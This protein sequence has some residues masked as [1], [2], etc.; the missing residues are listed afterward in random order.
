MKTFK[1]IIIAS[2]AFML[3]F[4]LSCCSSDTDFITVGEDPFSMDD[5]ELNNND[6]NV[7]EEDDVVLSSSSSKK[8]SSSSSSENCDDESSSKSTTKKDGG[9]DDGKVDS[10][11]DGKDDGKSGSKD[12]DKP[13]CSNSKEEVTSSSKTVV[14]SSSKKEESSS[15]QKGPEAESSSSSKKK[16][17][18]GMEEDEGETKSSASKDKT[19]S[20]SEKPVVSS[21]SEKP[22]VSSSSEA[23]KDTTQ[24]IE[25]SER[26]ES[27]DPI[28][29]SA[30]HEIE[31]LIQ[32]GDSAIVKVDSLV[33]DKQ[34]M[35]FD[36]NEYLCK[37]PDGSWYKLR[38]KKFKG[39][40]AAL[41]DLIYT[42]ITGN[43]Y[44]DFTN[45]CDELYIRPKS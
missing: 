31:K 22:V 44:Y 38:E 15:S 5:E 26:A 11:D 19:S 30:Q 29:S 33:L 42:W 35:D 37:A 36:Q 40:L 24:V 25:E 41:W 32:Q 14:S 39:T 2:A 3:A 7:D 17:I 9:K 1:R 27:M 8:K 28:T 13:D 34:D 12:S 6:E 21:S 10:K 45:V 16:V 43:H 20:S 23:K 4:S 18:P